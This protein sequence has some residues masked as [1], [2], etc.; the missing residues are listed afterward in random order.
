M[1][2]Q[3]CF[4]AHIFSVLAHNVVHDGTEHR[5]LPAEVELGVVGQHLGRL[6]LDV[7]LG[8]EQVVGGRRLHLLVVLD[9]GVGLLAA[10]HDLVL[11][12]GQVLLALLL[13]DLEGRI[14]TI[15]V[16]GKL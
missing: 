5:V 10:P 6:E 8:E 15:I 2:S 11:Q 14:R 16:R 3:G 9:V 13:H 7:L 1:L 4:D 12:Y